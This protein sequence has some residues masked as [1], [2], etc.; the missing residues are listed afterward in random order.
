MLSI[1]RID[2]IGQVVGDLEKQVRLLEG[3]FGFRRTRAWESAEEGCRGVLLDVPGSWGQRWEVLSP[4]GE[5]SAYHA[6]LD[7]PLGPGLHHVAVQVTDLAAARKRLEE[8][9]ID[10]S[11]NQRWI[12]VPFAPPAG[13]AGIGFRIFAPPVLATCG[14]HGAPSG[15]LETPPSVAPN[16]GIV[17]I[18]QIGQAYPDREVLARWCEQAVGMREVYRTPDG[19]HSD[20]ATL[21]LTIPGTQMRWELIAPVGE[22]SFVQ[23]FL[24]KRG[25]GAAHVTFEVRDFEQ[26]MAAAEHHGIPTFDLHEGETDGAR[27]RDWFI[28]PRHTGGFLVQLFWEERPGVWSR[29]DKVPYRR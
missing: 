4:L 15:A 24:N 12:D 7:G 2:H 1:Y 29:S 19:Q 14:D 21:V 23:S 26:A 17:G 6:F 16:L 11:E 25:A 8:L 13:P 28:H 9:A 5:D 18:E 27:W 3:L 10:A 22:A 20:M